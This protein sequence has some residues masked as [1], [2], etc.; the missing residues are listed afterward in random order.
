MSR[1]SAGDTGNT[2]NTHADNIGNL[3]RRVLALPHGSTRHL[4]AIA[5]PPASGKSTLARRVA[6][7]LTQAG[8]TA[9]VVPMDGFHLDNELLEQRGLLD[10]KGAPQTFD[11]KGFLAL[12]MRLSDPTEQTFPLFDRAQDRAVADAGQIT[13]GCDVAIVEGN[14]LLLDQDPW[15][16]LAD[17]WAVSV[18]LDVPEE[19]LERRLVERWLKHGRSPAKALAKARANDLM[20]AR[21]AV[22]D[23]LV[24]HVTLRS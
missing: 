13:A 10:R 22:A 12:V 21:T 20:N 4:V 18:W 24:A 17:L 11:A 9:Q 16:H 8:R 14:Y 3:V 23:R 7:A 1:S 2:G 19:T 6:S 15:R 5:G